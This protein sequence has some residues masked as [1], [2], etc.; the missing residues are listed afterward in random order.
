MED[1]IRGIPP[2]SCEEVANSSNSPVAIHSSQTCFTDFRTPLAE[3]Q[4]A[5]TTAV[6]ALRPENPPVL[7]LRH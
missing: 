1:V 6:S 5:V 2:A 3:G 4:A 7:V